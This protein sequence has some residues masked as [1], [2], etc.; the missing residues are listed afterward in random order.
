MNLP[1]KT[2]VFDI[3]FCVATLHNM[4]DKDGVK[5]GIKE[6][7]RLIK[8]RGL[9]FFDLENYLNPMNWQLL[10]PIKILHAS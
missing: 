5:K 3:S 9:I 7:H 1:F 4:P 8:D 2:G 10:I 6:M